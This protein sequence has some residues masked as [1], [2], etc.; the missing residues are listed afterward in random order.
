MLEM[1][2][3]FQKLQEIL[4]TRAGT[5]T[6]NLLLTDE[7]MM[8]GGRRLIQLGHTSTNDCVLG[9][10]CETQHFIING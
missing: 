8:L 5:R 10:L 4:I 6:L 7:I 1:K 3:L 2:A 9:W